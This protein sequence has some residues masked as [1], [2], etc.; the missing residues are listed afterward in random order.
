MLDLLSGIQV[1]SFN[2]FLMGPLGIQI[3]A[4]MGADVICVEPLEGGFQ[5]RFG[6]AKS[7]IDG[8]GSSFHLAGRNKRNIALNLKHE[9]GVEIAR[10][11]IEK[12]DVVTENFRPGV[13]ERLGLGYDTLARLNPSLIYAAATGFG[14][15]GP[16]AD[17]PGQDLLIQ[18]LSGL[19]MISGTRSGGP[20]AVGVSIADH[21]GAALYALGILGGLIRRQ[22][23]GRGCYVDVDLMSAAIDLQMESFVSY[24]NGNY[25]ESLL[26]PEQIGG[27]Y[28]AAPY[29]IYAAKNGH[30][31]ISHCDL[32]VLADG[33]ELPALKAYISADLFDRREEVAGLISEKL[34]TLDC[35]QVMKTLV[36]LKVWC[37]P[38]NDYDTVISD[39]QVQHNQNFISTTS[40]KGTPMTLVNHPVRYDGQAAEVRIPPQPLGAQSAEILKEL[41]WDETAIAGLVKANVIALG[42]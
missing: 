25:R 35:R 14:A 12:A 11:L 29:G 26:S 27:W 39:S 33:L 38:V 36:S 9:T 7:Y 30:L 37:A 42:D 5:R 20:R 23:S 18:A 28:N 1:V 41:G 4:D 15:S 2:H 24:F 3:L 22:R 16:G 19:A 13:M 32:G 34:S 8:D 21:H 6:G 40:A 17:R 31:A 10:A